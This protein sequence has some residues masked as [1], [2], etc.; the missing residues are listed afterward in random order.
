MAGWLERLMGQPPATTPVARTNV[1]DTAESRYD[2]LLNTLTGLGGAGDKGAAGAVN[3]LHYRLT[4]HDLSALWEANG[5]ARRIVALLPDEATRK[6]WTVPDLGEEEKRLKVH[7]QVHDAMLWARLYGGAVVLK[8]TEDDVPAEFRDRPELW[9]QQPLDLAR[10]GRVHAFH[11]FDALEARPGPLETSVQSPGYRQPKWWDITSEGRTMRVHGSRVAHFRGAQRSPHRRRRAE[12][13]PDDS[14]LQAVWDEVYRL[15]STM[16]SGA[17][18]AQEIRESVLRINGLEKLSTGAGAEAVEQRVRLMARAKSLVGMVLIGPGDEYSNRSNPP[19][20]FKELSG[21]ARTML[22]GVVGWPQIVLFGEAPAGLNSDGASGWQLMNRN[23]SAYQEAHRD[24]IESLYTVCY[25]AQDGSTK[26]QVPDEA[27]VTFASLD[28]SSDKERAEARE[29]MARTDAIYLDRG[30]LDVSEVRDGRFGEEGW[31]VDL[32]ELEELEEDPDFADLDGE[33]EGAEGAEG[34]AV[35]VATPDGAAGAPLQATALNGAQI[36][37]A[38]QLLVDVG[39]RTIQRESGIVALQRFFSMTPAEA[40][41]LMGETG[42]TFFIEEEPRVDAA[43][44][45][46]CVMV[47]VLMSAT[48]APAVLDELGIGLRPAEGKPHVTLLYLGQV[49]PKHWNEVAD[50][51]ASVLAA[52]RFDESGPPQ[53]ARLTTFGGAHADGVPVVFELESWVLSRLHDELLRRL[54]HLVTAKQWPRYRPHVT[55]GYAPEVTAEQRLA[56]VAAADGLSPTILLDE[57]VVSGPDDQVLF[58]LPWGQ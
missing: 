8:V 11:V 50:T 30:I 9:L 47:N 35:V 21:E 4:H 27:M 43:G 52:W 46:L 12:L 54:A 49:D 57:V 14:V 48:N 15:G 53:S 10:I 42:K 20:G 25:S 31:Q 56:L 32:R 39:K 45:G 2:S 19:T 22:A 5:I 16:Q 28:E 34:S 37:E 36:R 44:H 33:G 29:I 38:F 24:L 23:T 58:S 1:W 7:A 41:A 3:L 55:L 6:G 40:E 17:V 18:L 51:V 26:G 13:M